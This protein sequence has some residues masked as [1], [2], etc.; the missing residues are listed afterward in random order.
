MNI[1]DKPTPPRNIKVTDVF[2][3][4]CIVHWGPPV[5]DGG[6]DITSYIVEAI[7]MTEAFDTSEK[8]SEWTAVGET[9]SGEDRSMYCPN[10]RHGH[11]YKFR[12]RAVNR[13][14]KSDPGLLPGDGILIKDP[15]GEYVFI[16]FFQFIHRYIYITPT[17]LKTG[18]Y[19]TA[20]HCTCEDVYQKFFVQSKWY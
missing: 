12:V 1:T 20:G 13:L 7:D 9:Q 19:T 16:V 2:Y 10:L 15:W 14:G 18:I 17:V 4:N 6:C 3:D 5:D 8:S 11:V